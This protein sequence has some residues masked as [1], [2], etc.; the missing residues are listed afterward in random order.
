MSRDVASVTI[1]GRAANNPQV[2]VGPTGERVNFRVIATERRFDKALDDF[3]DGDQFGV[4][5]VCWKVLG[6]AVLNTVRKGDP[7]L[8]AGRIAT[9]R[10]EKNGITQYFTEVKADFVGMDVAKFGSRFTRKAIEPSDTE[11]AV[12]SP[13]G[14]QGTADRTDEL[15][16]QS[17][18]MR[19]LTEQTA[20]VDLGSGDTQLDRDD[21]F[22]PEWDDRESQE[23]LES[24]LAT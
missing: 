9:R 21:D 7:V 2:T 16:L 10:F 22:D 20:G 12:G 11:G 23:E 24:A 15:G 1:V 18:T 8:V 13:T 14:A 19:S 5:V 3:V 6:N 17:L 4:T